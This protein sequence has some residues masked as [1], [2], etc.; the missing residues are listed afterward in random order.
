MADLLAFAL[1]SLLN[2]SLLSCDAQNVA[3]KSVL[4][5]TSPRVA[6]NKDDKLRLAGNGAQVVDMETCEV[7]SAAYKSGVPAVV[8]RVV[9]D[10]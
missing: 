1:R 9:S 10:Y 8:V 4:G 6:I 5:T 3:C 2:V 7:L